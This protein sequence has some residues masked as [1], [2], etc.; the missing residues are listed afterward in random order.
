MAFGRT[1]ALALVAALCLS[2]LAATA[3]TGV[4]ARL[5]Y[6]EKQLHN[7]FVL[8]DKDKD[9]F[10]TKEE[11]EAGNMPATAKNFDAIDTT[12]RGKVSEKEIQQFMLKHMADKAA[13]PPK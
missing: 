2:P 1:C 4:G 5:N 3:Q 8:A 10:V 7:K 11:A 6:A 9:G 12:K 13:T